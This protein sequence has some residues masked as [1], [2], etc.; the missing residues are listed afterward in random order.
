MVQKDE[1][2]KLLQIL[3]EAQQYVIDGNEIPVDYARILFPPSRREYELT[4]YGKETSQNIIANA[5]AV[6]FQIEKT[7]SN[8]GDDWQNKLIFGDNLQVLKRLLD[9]K[10]EGSLKNADGTDG[11]R[12]V[13][14]DPPF[15]T[16][17][18]FNAS[19]NDQKAYADKIAGAEFLE[20]LR[21]RLIIMK[22]LLADGGS[23]YVHLDYRKEHYVKVLM[24]EIF[25]ES[26]F[27]NEIIWCYTGPSNTKDY[28]PRKHDTI[29]LYRKSNS[30]A[31]FNSNEIRIA[32]KKL[33]TGKT[34]GIFKKNYRLNELGKIP[35]DWWI[36]ISPVGR[37]KD[38]LVNYPTQ[39]PEALIERII[40]A[41]SNEGDIVLDCFAGSGTTP[42]V[43]E[44]MNRRWVACD[45]GKLSIYTIQKRL[46][47]LN[48]IKSF[49]LYS[50]GLYDESEL[51]KFDDGEWR[52]F[53]LILWGCKNDI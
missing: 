14:I 46:L 2:S 47:K 5:M 8:R 24:D 23:I 41:S 3:A 38:E 27:I 50:A 52:T 49:N 10:K 45:V 37:L 15:S 36:D 29:L 33:E 42:V 16:R 6:P 35:E 25:G 26:N 32:Y 39:K 48:D 21:K 22:E 12:L 9:M 7:F 53:A 1:Q 19:G 13:Y 28:F 31:T 4:Y 20:W 30:N 43:A 44:K 11:I 17:K 51:N 18:D 34:Q 40:K